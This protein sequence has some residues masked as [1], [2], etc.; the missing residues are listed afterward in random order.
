[1]RGSARVAHS[2]RWSISRRPRAT[3]PI[4]NASAR[5]SIPAITST[6]TTPATRPWGTPSTWASSPANPLPNRAGRVGEGVT[7][8]GLG[9]ALPSSNR[10]C[11]FPASG[12]VKSHARP[13]AHCV[14]R[15]LRE[16][17]EGAA[18]LPAEDQ[19]E[20]TLGYRDGI[21]QFSRG[22]VDE[23]LPGGK[24]DVALTILC[25]VLS[26]LLREY[27]QAGKSPIRIH[28]SCVSPLFRFVGD[29]E[30]LSRNGFHQTERL[31][32]ISEFISEVRLPL[33]KGILG[34]NKQ[35]AVRRDVLVGLS[36]RYYLGEHLLQRNIFVSR[37][38]KRIGEI[39]VDEVIHGQDGGHAWTVSR[40][41]RLKDGDLIFR[42]I[43][44]E[45]IN[46]HTFPAGRNHDEIAG[47]VEREI[48]RFERIIPH[49]P[50][51]L[52]FRRPP[53]NALRVG[54]S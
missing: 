36:C 14:Q 5:S 31:Q 39:A 20:G 27:P 45:G 33:N 3:Q 53:V 10:R 7:A 1:M 32:N 37:G 12:S 40:R 43:R 38:G 21:D 4:P 2:T 51:V 8:R 19:V 52:G 16:N 15:G 41:L 17:E 6:P 54:I 18:I 28:A 24:I 25:E 50:E 46:R 13:R 42:P 9:H 34:R 29:V 44:A 11:G 35:R 30:R 47:L 49:D 22:A 48:H 26:T 23:H